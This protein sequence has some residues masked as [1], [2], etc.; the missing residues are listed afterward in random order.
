MEVP[1]DTTY[2]PTSPYEGVDKSPEGGKSL[3]IV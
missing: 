3:L 1:I 2:Q